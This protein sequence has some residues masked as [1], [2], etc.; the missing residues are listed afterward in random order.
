MTTAHS[1]RDLIDYATS[2]GARHLLEHDG[3]S[4]RRRFLEA[5]APQLDNMV[6]ALAACFKWVQPVMD[7]AAA[8]RTER[9]DLLKLL[10]LGG[11]DD[12]VVSTKLLLSGKHAASGNVARR[13]IEG[14]AMAMLCSTA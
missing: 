6:D 11:I 14:A 12:L 1:D 4:V 5:L 2:E 10:A 3:I 9:T 8:M 7:A 13:A